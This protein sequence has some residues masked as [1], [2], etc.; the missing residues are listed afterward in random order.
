MYVFQVGLLND[1][2]STFMH[3]TPHLFVMMSVCVTISGVRCDGLGSGLLAIDAAVVWD[4][5]SMNKLM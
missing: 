3:G 4:P 5:V 1:Q 2:V